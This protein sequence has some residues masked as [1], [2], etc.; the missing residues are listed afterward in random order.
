MIHLATESAE[1]GKNFTGGGVFPF[2]APNLPG[3]KIGYVRIQLEPS[4]IAEAG[5]RWWVE[6]DTNLFSTSQAIAGI[7]YRYTIRFG[8]IPGY[9]AP[10]Q[11]TVSLTDRNGVR[12]DADELALALDVGDHV[13][14]RRL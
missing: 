11:Q 5:A 12:V 10:S 3:L 6:G 8:G 14:D 7:E 2:G 9:L 4:C 13:V 1:F